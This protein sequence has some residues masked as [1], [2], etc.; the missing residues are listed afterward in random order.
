MHKLPHQLPSSYKLLASVL[1]GLDTALFVVPVESWCIEN[2]C[3]E[4]R[5]GLEY[6]ASTGGVRLMKCR[7]CVAA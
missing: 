4:F 1:L 5:E 3:E 6:V 2:V 7:G